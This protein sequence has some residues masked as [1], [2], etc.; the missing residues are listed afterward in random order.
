MKTL[1]AILAL[2]LPLSCLADAGL[3]WDPSPSPNVTG[4]VLRW[5]TN[6]GQYFAATNVGN[7]TNVI[8][9]NLPFAVGTNYVVLSAVGLNGVE[10]PRTAEIQI[11]VPPPPKNFRLSLEEAPSPDGPWTE[12]A[13]LDYAGTVSETRFFRGKVYP[14]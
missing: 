14:P 6:S 2:C 12:V 3:F 11:V 7:V 8:V 5:G 10:S 9:S 13:C 4:Y 1:L